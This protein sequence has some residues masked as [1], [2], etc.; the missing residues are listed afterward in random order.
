MEKGRCE[1]PPPL[2]D[3]GLGREL[4]TRGGVFLAAGIEHPLLAGASPKP[5]RKRLD[6]R[7]RVRNPSITGGIGSCATPRIRKMTSAASPGASALEPI[8]TPCTP[9]FFI[10]S[11]ACSASTIFARATSASEIG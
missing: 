6:S 8:P 1:S 4:E 2:E 3:Y 10:H 11:S 9:A 7:T 5:A